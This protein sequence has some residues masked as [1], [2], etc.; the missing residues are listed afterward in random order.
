MG[1][2]YYLVPFILL[3]LTPSGRPRTRWIT[4]VRE[5]T[6][7]YTRRSFGIYHRSCSFVINNTKWVPSIG[8]GNMRRRINTR[9]D[10]PRTATSLIHLF[11][12]FS[13]LDLALSSRIQGIRRLRQGTSEHVKRENDRTQMSIFQLAAV[14]TIT[15]SR[16]VWT[17]GHPRTP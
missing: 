10:D 17:A 12:R 16:K 4:T 14:D 6:S 8:S 13:N 1:W 9:G 3:T 2:Y 7:E 15:N 5:P 11:S